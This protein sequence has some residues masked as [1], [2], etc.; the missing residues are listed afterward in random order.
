MPYN[1]RRMNTV[2]DTRT[3]DSR[4][5]P[6]RADVRRLGA[7]LGG[8][9]Q[10]QGPEWLYDAVESS[11]RAAIRRRDGDPRAQAELIDALKDRSSEEAVEITRAFS[12]WFQ[13]VNLAERVHRIRRLNAYEQ[14]GTPTPGG[15]RAVLAS[16]KDEG[17]TA[18]EL[19]T[20][21]RDVV[22]EPVLTAH[23]TESVRRTMLVKELRMAAALIERREDVE[24]PAHEHTKAV[25]RVGEELVAAW[26]TEEHR[27]DKPTVADEREHALFFLTTSLWNAVPTQRRALADALAAVYGDDAESLAH[28]PQLRFASWI[29]GDMDG[30]PNVGADTIRASLARHAG[31]VLDLYGNDIREL[32]RRLSQSRTRV[33][34]SAALDVRL[35]EYQKRMPFVVEV[36]PKRYDGMPYRELLWLMSARLDGKR[37]GKPHG[38]G[39]PTELLED[40]EIIVESLRANRGAHAGMAAVEDL[41]ERVRVF[42]FHLATLDVRQDALVHR[43]TIASLLGDADFASR[44]GGERAALLT[45][46]LERGVDVATEARDEAA[47]RSLDVMRAIGEMRTT[48]GSDAIG[49]Y[50]ISMAQGPDDALAVLYIARAGG[51]VDEHVPLDVAP[52]FETVDDLES[53]PAT[54]QSLLDDSAYREH[55]AS[56]GNVQWVMLGYSD[57]SKTS[58]LIASRVALQ[59]AQL[60]LVRIAEGAGVTLRFFHGRGGTASRGG[61]KPRQAILAAPRGTLAGNLRVTEQGEI[62]QA[63]FGLDAIAERTLELQLGATVERTVMDRERAAEPG[64]DIMRE[65][66]GNA[67]ATYRTLLEDNPDFIPYFRTATPIDVIER[68]GLGSRPSRRREMRGVEDLRAIPWV[69][70]WTQ[71]RLL[72]PGWYGSGTALDAAVKAHGLP[73]LRDLARDSSFFRTM[74]TDIEMVLAKAELGIA[75]HYAGLAGE[76]GARMFE[77]LAAEFESTRQHVQ[78]I[79]EVDVLLDREPLLQ[80]AIQLRNPY[81]DPMS[82]LQV[83]LLARWRSDGS[84]DDATL[85]AL[86]ATVHGLARG[87]QNTG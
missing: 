73:A 3:T 35:A 85:H 43:E 52:L 54:L 62:I 30:N 74:L 13:L 23:P 19:E 37:D 47:A 81:I 25:R 5:Q 45:R 6:L 79:L 76:S 28:L 68:L 46:A 32:F 60:D 9:L 26:Q 42:G 14:A 20:V 66:A 24:A 22:I 75:R 36:I 72:L 53:A 38:Y 34:V 86:F 39:E 2:S 7:L 63:K 82:F 84:E 80:R 65:L 31:L 78:D 64:D 4:H 70:A 58:G 77:H 33:S 11:R 21:L 12:A 40:L 55:L 1:P 49:K 29:G 16:L 83:D 18:G 27:A 48:Y 10:E 71:C 87:M 56:R 57:S 44:S 67:R 51:L 8:L 41:A 50:I 15:L 59:H 69:F 17:I 61:T